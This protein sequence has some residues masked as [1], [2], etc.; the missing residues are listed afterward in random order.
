MN[1]RASRTSRE[2]VVLDA[3]AMVDLLARTGD[4]FPAVRAR[5]ART[6]LHAPAHFDAEVLSAL[7]RLQRGGVLTVDHVGAALAELQQAPVT[8][9][10][11]P[12]LLAGAW[13]RRDTFRLA[14]A[15]YVELADAAGMTLLTTDQRLARAWPSAEVIV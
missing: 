13:S 14:D 12:P 11:L 4:R 1:P 2:H 8:R 5:L 15:L 9:H 7:G 3:S 10:D 6:V